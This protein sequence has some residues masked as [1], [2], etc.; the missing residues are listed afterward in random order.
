MPSYKAPVDDVMFLL[1][2][3]LDISRYHNL[4]GFEEATSD[5]I[6]AILEE[7][8]KICEA[9][10]QPLNQAGDREGC[11]RG[12]DGAVT[13]PEGFKAA[14][15][16]YRAGGFVGLNMPAA[17]GGL[18]LPSTLNAVMQEFVSSANLALGMYPGL[19]QGAIAALLVHGSDGQKATY[20][21]KMISGEWSGTMNL[22][23]PHCGTDL[24]LLRT[25]AA[26]Q[27]DGSYAITGQK[28]FISA[29]EHDL[30]SNIVHL[31]LARIEGAPAGTKGISLFVCPKILVEADGSLGGA[32]CRRLRQGR[33]EDGHPRQLDL[34]DE[35]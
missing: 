7:G 20:L 3:V 9:E 13:T 10:F 8:A 4:P 30:T 14:Y 18:G 31:V 6:R 17:Y 35:L 29:G 15:D 22:T 23:E 21:P 12:D 16:A 25:R 33:G 28:I 5:T 24:G 27:P 2:D 34:R 11:H 32:Q 19:T 1:E 26:K